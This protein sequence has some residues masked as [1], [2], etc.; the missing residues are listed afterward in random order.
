MERI[1]LLHVYKSYDKQKVLEDFNYTFAD[2]GGYL[3]FGPS[4]CGKTT[5]LNIIAGVETADSGSYYLDGVVSHQNQIYQEMTYIAQDVYL[6]DYLTIRENLELGS[7]DCEQIEHFSKE[8][9][10]EEVL[11]AYPQTLSGGEGQRTAIIRALCSNK[12][13]LL[14]DEPTANLDEENKIKIFEILRDLSKEMLVICISHDEISKAYFHNQ[15]DFN[16][17][18]IYQKEID[19]PVIQDIEK[20]DT[21]EKEVK[22]SFPIYNYVSKQ[23][24]KD[25]KTSFRIL[26][27]IFTISFL[28]L[29]FSIKPEDKVVGSLLSIY[30]LNYLKVRF[31]LADESLIEQAKS[32]YEITTIVYPYKEGADYVEKPSDNQV[33]VDKPEYMDSLVYETLPL[34]D[35]YKYKNELISGSYFDEKNQVMLGYQKAL[36]Y[37]NDPAS[38]IGTNMEI[39]TPKGKEKFEITGV[40]KHLEEEELP[41][42]SYGYNSYGINN[43]VF[44]NEAYTKDYLLDNKLSNIE[45]LS[46]SG[47]YY[48]IYFKSQEG[49]KAFYEEYKDNEYNDKNNIYI[50]P[51]EDSFINEV[52]M[53]EATGMILI[54]ISVVAFIL[55]MFFYIFSKYS[56]MQRT[57]RNFS[58]FN[59]YGYNWREVYFAYNRYFVCQIAK[60]I[61]YAVCFSTGLSWAVNAVNAKCYFYA[62]P[63][64]SID[65]TTLLFASM[66]LFISLSILICWMIARFRRDT[67]FSSLK[68]GRD[69]L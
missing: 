53:F 34:K 4:G 22:E 64:F 16:D 50:K 2:K 33:V 42:L 69:L 30:D 20:M 19:T 11:D 7:K 17:L 26:V 40:F 27:L 47:R 44:F 52:S 45:K 51:I 5:L 1:R 9:G 39:T 10:I 32:D 15:I 67:W 31:P 21:V 14:L 46:I 57:R 63:L 18:C 38:I 43:T 66:I 59:Y 68:I 3:F 62:F 28:I 54:P 65:I 60:S 37:T 13:I 29:N 56:Q 8:F 6:I 25:E 12:K 61:L 41:Y 58:V 49:L 55:S 48:I 24:R 36:E 23:R 35:G